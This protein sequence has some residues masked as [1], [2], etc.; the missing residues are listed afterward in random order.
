MRAAGHRGVPVPQRQVPQ[1]GPQVVQIR[2]DQ[3]GRPD[4]QY[5]LR[6]IHHVGRSQPAVQEAGDRA[7]LLG[8]GAEESHDVVLRLGAFNLRDPVRRAHARFP[9]QL[10]RRGRGD[11]L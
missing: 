8:D 7:G 4:Q 1:R 5:R 9:A 10:F 3:I 6:R 11:D 2:V